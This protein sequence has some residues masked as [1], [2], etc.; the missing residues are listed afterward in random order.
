MEISTL[1]FPSR[2]NSNSRKDMS[3]KSENAV[4]KS[5]PKDALSNGVAVYIPSALY[6]VAGKE[7][8]TLGDKKLEYPIKI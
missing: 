8:F 2:F 5:N 1:C 7:F 6:I 3:L 4:S